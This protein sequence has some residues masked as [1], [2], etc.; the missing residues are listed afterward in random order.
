MKKQM[1]CRR[2]FALR[3]KHE[4]PYKMQDQGPHTVINKE[5]RQLGET[6]NRPQEP[7]DVH[8]PQIDA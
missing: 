1:R 5:I 4:F 3:A 6:A 8:E 2:P 7:C